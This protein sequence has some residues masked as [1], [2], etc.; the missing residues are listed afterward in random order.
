[1]RGTCL[2]TELKVSV[3]VGAIC[4]QASVFEVWMNISNNVFIV[5][6]GASGLASD[7]AMIVA[8]GGGLSWRT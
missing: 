3:P 4:G 8:R 7:G 2:K 5:T 6:G 1:M